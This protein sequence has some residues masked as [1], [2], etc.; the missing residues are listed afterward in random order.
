LI[1]CNFY[2]LLLQSSRLEE[3]LAMLRRMTPQPTNLNITL[4][5]NGKHCADHVTSPLTTSHGDNI[6]HDAKDG[7]QNGNM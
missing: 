5:T 3:I 4:Q 7:G 1:Y 6:F 2:G